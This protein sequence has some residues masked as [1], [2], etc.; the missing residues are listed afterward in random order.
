VLH[1]RRSTVFLCPCNARAATV[2]I[3]SWRATEVRAL[4]NRLL[5]V[6]RGRC[7]LNDRGIGKSFSGSTISD[8]EIQLPVHFVIFA[9]KKK[10]HF[11]TEQS[12]KLQWYL[13]SWIP[14]S[15]RSADSL[16]RFYSS[17]W[18]SCFDSEDDNLT[19]G[20]IL[21]W[22]PIRA[23]RAVARNEGGQISRRPDR[24]LGRTDRIVILLAVLSRC[25]HTLSTLFA[26]G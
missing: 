26:T 14:A 9:K 22:M 10:C 4:R 1:V 25:C 2:R 18:L 8:S 21:R 7:W 24:T 6:G 12:S 13:Q 20:W 16:G 11:S 19:F 5:D 17:T 23:H 3:A 15:E